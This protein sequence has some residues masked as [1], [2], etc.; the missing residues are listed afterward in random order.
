V[1][2]I[3]PSGGDDTVA[4]QAAINSQLSGDVVL[5][6]GTYNVSGPISL[7]SHVNLIGQSARFLVTSSVG[8]HN[9]VLQGSALSGVTISGSL[10]IIGSGVWSAT[11]FANPYGGGNSVGFTNSEYGVRINGGNNIQISGV[12]C[13]GLD[14]GIMVSG[15]NITINGGNNLHDLGSFGV[16]PTAVVG[17]AISGNAIHHIQGGLTAAGDTNIADSKFADGIYV[18]GCQNLSIDGND[19]DDV[20]RIG[21]VL[22]GDGITLNDN[23]TINANVVSNVH[24]ARGT[25]Y[26]GAIWEESGKSTTNNFITNNVC[27]NVGA[28]G[29]KPC[30]GAGGILNM[31]LPLANVTGNQTPGW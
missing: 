12:E 19:I 29:V 9:G 8:F 14:G 3:H 27:N 26:N 1:T 30:G 23:V 18:H 20:I 25:E 17:G 21:I 5:S 31:D 13:S 6:A 10:A 16:Y 22:E 24:G 2:V 28:V 4:I 15:T 7:K 11:P